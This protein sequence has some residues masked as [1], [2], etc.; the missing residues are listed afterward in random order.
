[1]SGT[2]FPSLMPTMSHDL[3]QTKRRERG[4]D[5]G[6]MRGDGTPEILRGWEVR[7]VL[8]PSL[9]PSHSLPSGG[10]VHSEDVYQRESP[11]PLPLSLPL[12]LLPTSRPVPLTSTNPTTTTWTPSDPR[13]RVRTGPESPVL[14]DGT[15][16]DGGLDSCTRLRGEPGGG[17]V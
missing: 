12:P 11:G 7:H 4:F 9:S 8:G 13:T 1:M 3:S 14:P 17:R 16:G 15:P 2:G 5:N 6:R 10:N